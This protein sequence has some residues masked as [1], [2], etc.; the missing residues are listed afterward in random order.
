MFEYH[1]WIT[2]RETAVGDDDDTRLNRIVEELR[3][4][5]DRMDSPYL[6]DLRWMN[7]E[8][9]VH[10]GGNSNHRSDP[11]IVA[12]FEHVATIAPGSYGLLHILDDEDPGH[13]N[14][15]RVLRLVRGTLTHHTEPLLSPCVPALEDPCGTGVRPRTDADLDDCVRVLAEV[16]GRD[17]YPL[18]W[19]DSPAVWLTPQALV[20]A[21]VAH[22]DGRVVG[23]VCLSR[24]GPGDA[25]PGLWS[26]RTGGSAEA[27]AVVNRLYVAPSARGHGIGALLMQRAV[28]AARERGLHPVLDV[29]ASDTAAAALYERLGWQLL[30]TVDQKW[31][32]ERTVSVRCYAAA[33]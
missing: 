15:V 3:L 24:G 23:H 4:K 27:S 31:G 7:G 16:H 22:R 21:W 30:A 2:V 12:L 8:P 26:A 20:A 5:I 32:P 9:F 11:D 1:G 28:A 18:N 6:L 13:E 19:P 10:V 25:A 29:V 14:E 17:G 33:P